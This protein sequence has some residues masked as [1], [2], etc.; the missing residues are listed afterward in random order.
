MGSIKNLRRIGASILV[1]IGTVA[2]ADDYA[3]PAAL[4]TRIAIV[5]NTFADQLRNHGYLEAL[6]QQH[7]SKSAVSLR[8]LGWAG[9]TLSHRDRPTNFPTEASTLSAHR[10]DAI[11]ACFGMSESFAG[12]SGLMDFK[13]DLEAF[14]RSHRGQSYNGSSAVRMILVSP[15]AYENLGKLTPRWEERNG[16]L[17]RYS[18]AMEEVASRLE[19]PFVDLF[20][21]TRSMMAESGTR[22]LTT[23]GIH[24]NEYGYW[25]VSRALY[26]GLV[27]GAPDKAEPWRV[28]LDADKGIVSAEGLELTGVANSNSS[29]RFQAKELRGPALP[30]PGEAN[31]S[32]ALSEFRDRLTVANLEPGNYVLRIDGERV[33]RASHEEWAKGVAVDASPVH[34][35]AERFR[36][37]IIDKNRQF[38]Y[39]WKALNQVHI[40]GERRNSASGRELPAEVIEFRE[41]A[42]RRDVDLAKGIPLETRQWELVLDTN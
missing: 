20:E 16:Q 32:K 25:A 38:E 14:I 33:A 36:E 42:K 11:I 3:G 8:N 30:P 1:L 37:S 26:D 41:I 5:G 34:R 39:S 27:A 29:I 15:I 18:R 19:V 17:Q 9:D 35:E 4:G 31:K 6:L 12:E 21:P 2:L 22:R 10:A 23:N 40:V 24:L 7:D 13:S 28:T